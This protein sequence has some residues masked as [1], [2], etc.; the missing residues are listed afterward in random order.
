MIQ[1]STEYLPSYAVNIKECV[2]SETGKVTEEE[3]YIGGEIQDLAVDP[4]GNRLAVSF[5]GSHSGSNLIILYSLQSHQSLRSMSSKQPRSFARSN[6]DL[7]KLGLETITLV[8]RG[9]IKG[10]V[11]DFGSLEHRIKP[12]HFHFANNIPRGALLIVS[13]SD[14]RI[15]FYPLYFS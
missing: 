8:P 3:V 12:M 1:E 13:W 14:G 5:E 6:A 11:N 15:S 2:N 9:F 7:S 4:S 10:V